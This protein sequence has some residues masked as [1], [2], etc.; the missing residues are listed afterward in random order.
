MWMYSHCNGMDIYSRYLDVSL[1]RDKPH[2]TGIFAKVCNGRFG[3]YLKD[4]LEIQRI[5]YDL[6]IT[7]MIVKRAL[8]PDLFVE[9]PSEYFVSWDNYPLTGGS[10]MPENLIPA[11]YNSISILTQGDWSLESLLHPYDEDLKSD[12]VDRFSGKVP[13]TLK[14]QEHPNGDYFRPYEAYFSYWKSYIFVEALDGY[15]HIDKFLSWETGREI[16]ISRFAVVSQQWEENYKDVFTRLSFYRTAK[17]ILTLWEAPRISITYKELS[18]FIQKV[19]NCNS[20]LLEQDMEKLLI[21]FG[22]WKKRQKEGRRYYPQAIELL[23]QDI[24]FLLEWLCTLNRKPQKVYFEKW[25]YNTEP[26]DIWVQLKEVIS[27]E[28]FELERRFVRYVPGYA[29][30]LKKEIYITDVKSVYARL[31]E[32][33]SF[34]PWIRAFSDLHDQLVHTSSKRP[35]VFKQSRILDHLLVLAIRTEI[36]IRAF[37]RKVAQLEENRDLRL[38]FNQFSI[39]LPEKSRERSILCAVA[40]KK[41]W[42]QTELSG[43][44]DEIFG[45][46]DLIPRKKKWNKSQHH[47]FL[48]ILRFVTARNYFAHHS[49]KDGTLNNQ[50]E[51]LPG[52]ILVSCLKS[53]IYMDYIV[54]KIVSKSGGK[55]IK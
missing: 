40:D 54:Q 21:L 27:Y 28:E 53:V 30:N 49:F 51:D 23:R 32:Y 26:H 1:Y 24:Y 2:S 25:S 39:K 46:I 31:A 42:R 17:T 38:V 6:S 13:R 7:D 12:F 19:T 4:R 20:E 15:E 36:L 45:N 8:I 47:I 34:W 55:S 3:H 50:V 29:E 33:E 41:T 10:E 52:Q 48:S 16:L 9:L 18:E 43:K 14:I 44:P 22:N 35:L 5:P 37:F 11:D